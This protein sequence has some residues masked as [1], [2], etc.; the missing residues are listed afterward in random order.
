MLSIIIPVY[1]EENTIGKTLSTLVYGDNIEVIVVDGGSQNKTVELAQQYPVKVICASKNR[2]LQMNKGAEVSYGDVLLF[3]HSDSWF[4][5]GSL[6][7]II[8]A[9]NNGCVGGC[10]SQRINSQRII[11][12][13]IEESGNIR[14]RLFKVFYGDQAIFVKRD[15]FFKVGGF[16]NVPLFED[17][18]FSQKMKRE[19]KTI[20]LNKKVF[21]SDRRW[22]RKGIIKTTFIF[23]LLTLGFQLNVPY[24]KLKRL[25]QDTR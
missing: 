20:V 23:C 19:G 3:L 9:L 21:V 17:I 7:E 8:Q 14:A 22:E 12:R 18:L 6:E 2:A 10:L 15:I 1:N 5:K 4:E 13:G 25:Y 16:D 24:D 11:Y